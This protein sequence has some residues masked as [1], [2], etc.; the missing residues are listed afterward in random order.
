LNQQDNSHNDWSEGGEENPT[1]FGTL[2]SSPKD[3]PNVSTA[4]VENELLDDINN[5][6][7]VIGSHSAQGA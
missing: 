1:P 5:A 2:N 3:K 6:Q 4:Q 7:L